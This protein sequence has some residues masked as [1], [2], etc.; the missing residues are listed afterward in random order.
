[1]ADTKISELTTATTP[2][3]G[4]EVVPVV[5]GGETRKVAVAGLVSPVL[6]A[7]TASFTTAQETKLAGIA[8]G[9]N[10]GIAPFSWRVITNANLEVERPFETF[11]L[12]FSVPSAKVGVPT[13]VDVHIVTD[14]VTLTNADCS[15]LVGA[16]V[17]ASS[18][19]HTFFDT[20]A[21]PLATPANLPTSAEAWT[22]MGLTTP[23]YQ[24]MQVTFTPTRTGPHRLQV[25]VRR[26]STTLFICPSPVIA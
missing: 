2:L 17:T 26:P 1:M 25:Q 18:T 23:V 24:R 12:M 9:A 3:A 6:A 4:T 19:I 20:A 10:D 5:Q 8:T 16:A 22:T 7:T 15:L 13:T 11:D 21:A 14:N